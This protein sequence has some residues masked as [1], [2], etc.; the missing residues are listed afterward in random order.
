MIRY[1]ARGALV[2]PVLPIGKPLRLVG[3][4]D[5]VR[6]PPASLSTRDGTWVWAHVD[7]VPSGDRSDPL[8]SSDP[9]IGGTVR[10]TANPQLCKGHDQLL[11]GVAHMHGPRRVRRRGAPRHRPVERIVDLEGRRV[12]AAARHLD[13]HPRRQFVSLP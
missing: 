8:W 3:S 5:P 13:P 11:G 9:A 10:D 6:P 12:T 2:D 4:H 1:E 7:S